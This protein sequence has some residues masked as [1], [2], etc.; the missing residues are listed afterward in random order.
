MRLSSP[1]DRFDASQLVK[2]DVESLSAQFSDEWDELTDWDET[3]YRRQLSMISQLKA[4]NVIEY[5]SH[6]ALFDHI[7][8]LAWKKAIAGMSRQFSLPDCDDSLLELNNK[9]LLSITD[10]IPSIKSHEKV[11]PVLDTYDLYQQV[12][13]FNKR[14]F[15]LSP[16]LNMRNLEI[17]PDWSK[18]AEKIEKQKN[19]LTSNPY[20]RYIKHINSVKPIFQT[21]E[22]LS[23][24][25]IK[26]YDHLLNEIESK[27]RNA[28]SYADTTEA[29]E[30]NSKLEFDFQLLIQQLYQSAPYDF[31]SNLR[32]IGAN[33][34]FSRSH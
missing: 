12:R 11:K 6:K 17:T 2:A 4:A 30:A 15:S 5:H 33:K 1:Q 31:I 28:Y 22:R 29:R 25:R 21:D 32:R 23:Q 26:Y 27:F 7:N 19:S 16:K 24:A 13:A 20:F 9:G 18:Y 10:R 8:T 34:I 14:S 3:L